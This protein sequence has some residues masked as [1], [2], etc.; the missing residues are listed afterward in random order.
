MRTGIPHVV[1]TLGKNGA[2]LADSDG[3]RRIPVRRTVIPVDTTGAGDSF[4]GA[5]AVAL[6]EGKSCED[7]VSWANDAA[8]LSVMRYGVIEAMPFRKELEKN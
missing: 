7:A 8:S 5:L 4:A 3:I 1:I 2:I 6:A